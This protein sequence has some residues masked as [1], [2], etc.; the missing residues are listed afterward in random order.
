[1]LTSSSVGSQVPSASGNRSQNTEYLLCFQHLPGQLCAL[2]KDNFLLLLNP[3]KEICQFLE[4]SMV[5]LRSARLLQPENS[6]S[7]YLI[8]MFI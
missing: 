3:P 1:M 8:S 6:F 7:K 4:I 2:E 5:P